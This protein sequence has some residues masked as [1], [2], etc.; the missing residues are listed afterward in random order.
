[1]LEY[2]NPTKTLVQ[3][4]SGEQGK[5][6]RNDHAGMPLPTKTNIKKLNQTNDKRE[7]N[8]KMRHQNIYEKQGD[9]QDDLIPIF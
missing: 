8:S 7:E 2:N 6:R 9:S 5:H 4:K 3:V 1:M